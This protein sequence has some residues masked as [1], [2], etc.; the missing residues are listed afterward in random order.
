[1][2]TWDLERYSS[3]YIRANVTDLGRS[4]VRDLEP[5]EKPRPVPKG[6]GEGL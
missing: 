1:V 6:E 5:L 3:P 2:Y 4:P